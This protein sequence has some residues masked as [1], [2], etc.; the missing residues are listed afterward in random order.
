MFIRGFVFALSCLALAGC[1]GAPPTYLAST[2]GSTSDW[3]SMDTVWGQGAE[4]L[5]GDYSFGLETPEDLRGDHYIY[6]VDR[7]FDAATSDLLPIETIVGVLGY[8]KATDRRVFVPMNR[9]N[10]VWK[11]GSGRYGDSNFYSFTHDLPGV[12]GE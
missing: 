11:S 10:K 8:D 1:A 9:I 2:G 12:E 6:Q 3:N 4:S 7:L 5:S